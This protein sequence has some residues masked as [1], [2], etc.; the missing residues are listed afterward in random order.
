MTVVINTPVFDGNGFTGRT[1]GIFAA[2]VDDQWRLYVGPT[3]SEQPGTTTNL[4]VA[5][6]DDAGED[7]IQI[8][9][10]TSLG[11]DSIFADGF[12]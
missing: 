5:V 1:P 11:I 8:A 7:T 12:E 3:F 6:V 4:A 10:P 2:T 9:F